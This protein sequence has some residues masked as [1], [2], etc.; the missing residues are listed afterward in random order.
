[1]FSI[2]DLDSLKKLAQILLWPLAA[3]AVYVEFGVVD[4]WGLPEKS[5][6]FYLPGYYCAFIFQ[7]VAVAVM[8]EAIDC[9]LSYFGEFVWQWILPI[10]GVC[11][12]TVG[13]LP[14][15]NIGQ[16]EPEIT[17][18]PLWSFAC[19]AWGYRIFLPEKEGKAE[20]SSRQ[21]SQRKSTSA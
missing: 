17:L 16:S 13:V 3:A 21:D 19:L 15:H 20:N 7:V 10:F 1:M 9:G 12:L 4:I 5:S 2:Q 8:I 14:L 18:S 6:F 11:L